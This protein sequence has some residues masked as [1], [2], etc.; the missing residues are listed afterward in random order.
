MYAAL[1]GPTCIAEVFQARRLIDRAQRQPWLVGFAVERDLSL[2]DLS[3]TWPT[4]AGASMALN[5]GPRPRAQRWSSAIYDAYPHLD[6]LWYP[7]SMHANAPAVALY[8]R[9]R[10]ALARAPFFHAPLSDPALFPS[11]FHLSRRLRYVLV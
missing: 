9:A 6:G 11:L 5:S 3:G 7:S 8:E 10:D 2:L 4:A 1:S